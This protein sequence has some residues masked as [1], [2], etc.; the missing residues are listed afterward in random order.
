MLSQIWGIF[1]SFS[2]SSF[3][4]VRPPL[5]LN[6]NPNSCLVAQIPTWRPKSQPG[7]QNPSS[8]NKTVHQKLKFQ[9]VQKQPGPDKHCFVERGH[10]SLEHGVSV[11]HVTFLVGRSICRLVGRSVIFL[12]SK[13]FLHYCSS[14][15]IR[16]LTTVYPAL[17]NYKPIWQ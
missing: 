15:T 8:M 14:P 12:N 7:G 5:D 9:V 17:L 1:S 2:F 4:S 6:S 13:R 10:T 11:G 16:D 3:F